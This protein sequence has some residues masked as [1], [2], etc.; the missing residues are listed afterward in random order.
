M[1]SQLREASHLRWKLQGDTLLPA[2][3][4]ST[5]SHGDLSTSTVFDVIFERYQTL[6]ART[7]DMLVRHVVSEVEGELKQHLTRWAR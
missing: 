5:L 1:A 3:F 6:I 2:T 4:R 7:E